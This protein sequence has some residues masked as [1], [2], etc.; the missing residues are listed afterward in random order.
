MK[1]TAQR[2]GCDLLKKINEKS[3]DIAKISQW[4]MQIYMQ[5]LR[6]IDDSLGTLLFELATMAD[7]PQFEYNKEQLQIIAD[8]LIHQDED[9]DIEERFSCNDVVIIKRTAPQKYRPGNQGIICWIHYLQNSNYPQICFV[10]FPD[11]EIVEI[12]GDFLIIFEKTKNSN[13]N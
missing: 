8:K 1:Y 13:Y 4:C 3:F 9:I 2:F 12:P 5:H 7:D 10:K 6:E 11:D